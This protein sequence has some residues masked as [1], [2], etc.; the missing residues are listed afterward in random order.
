MQ[1]LD[2]SANKLQGAVPETWTNLNLSAFSLAGNSG[3][4]LNGQTEG[5]PVSSPVY[6]SACEASSPQLPGINPAYPPGPSPACRP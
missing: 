4:C 3:M 2:L 5:A 6:Y 1:A